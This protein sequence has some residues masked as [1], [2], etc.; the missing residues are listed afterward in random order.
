VEQVVSRRILL[1]EDTE[2]NRYLFQDLLELEGYAVRSLPDGFAFFQAIAEFT[3]DII[4]LD[5]RLPQIDGYSLLQQLQQS[6]YQSIPVIVI[7][8]YGFQKE[9]QKA[10]SLGARAYLT[11]PVKLEELVRTLEALI[12]SSVA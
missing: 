3:P 6:P 7:S 11:K 4:L 9:K 8:A 2:A 12:S 10:M 5:L 1:V